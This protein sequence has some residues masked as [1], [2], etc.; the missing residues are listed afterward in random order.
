[1]K[2]K[3]L[4]VFSFAEAWPDA[5]ST[6]LQFSNH[7]PFNSLAIQPKPY[8]R[9]VPLAVFLSKHNEQPGALLRILP[10]GRISL[11]HYPS[12]MFQK[13]ATAVHFQVVPAYC[14]GPFL[15]QT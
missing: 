14:A 4:H 5:F 6:D 2:H 11:H 3:Y 12:R 7:S 1:M 13:G 10:N 9:F 8:Y 15:N